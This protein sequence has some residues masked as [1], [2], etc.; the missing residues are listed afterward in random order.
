MN[1][2][3][4]DTCTDRLAQFAGLGLPVLDAEQTADRLVKCDR[5][6]DGRRVCLECWHLT[7]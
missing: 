7:G 3:E 4:R 5:E 1:S 6:N 2:A